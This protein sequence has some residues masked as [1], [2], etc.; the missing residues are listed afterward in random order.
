MTAS[1]EWSA[2]TRRQEDRFPVRGAACVIEPDDEE[3]EHVSDLLHAMGFTVHETPSGQVGAF[4]ADQI[5]LEVAVVNVML[6]DVKALKLI[7]RLR[8]ASPRAAIVAMTPDMRTS[9]PLM[10]ARLAG[11]DAAL[12]APISSE[13]LGTAVT[14]ARERARP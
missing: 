12:A 14:E 4:I 3:R 7:R 11:A 6:E 1:H 5:E 10:L 8:K 13:A 9:L 2:R